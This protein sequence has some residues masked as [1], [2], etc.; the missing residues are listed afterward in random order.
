MLRVYL[1]VPNLI[2]E[3]GVSSHKLATASTKL[4]KSG[5]TSVDP[6]VARENYRP[7]PLLQRR[8]AGDWG[9][10]G[11]G[12]GWGIGDPRDGEGRKDDLFEGRISRSLYFGF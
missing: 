5:C 11:V 4:N 8:W 10:V 3:S 12:L 7:R 9:A 2:G 1:F 6:K